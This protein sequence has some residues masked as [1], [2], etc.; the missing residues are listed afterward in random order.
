MRQKK[1]VNQCFDVAKTEGMMDTLIIAA[2]R[3]S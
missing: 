1:K 3:P 2:S